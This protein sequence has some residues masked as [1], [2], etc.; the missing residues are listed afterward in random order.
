MSGPVALAAIEEGRI[1]GAD[2][3]TPTLTR[4]LEGGKVRSLAQIF[5]AIA[6]RFANTGWFTLTDYADK[7]RSVVEKFARAIGEANAYC[8][9]HHA[10]TVQL[11][12]DSAKIDPKVVARMARITFGD[13]LRA[14][15]IQPL[16]NVAAKYGAIAK[17][18]DARALISPYALKPSA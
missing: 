12:A 18:F 16:V 3:N 10:E 13:Y 2:L 15:D 7:N 8:N 17:P 1:D 11:V 6:P 14:S 9:A 5:D 4:G